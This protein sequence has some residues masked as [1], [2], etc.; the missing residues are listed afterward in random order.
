[1]ARFT[2]ICFFIT[3]ILGLVGHTSASPLDLLKRDCYNNPSDGCTK[4][5]N[6]FDA[7]P[8]GSCLGVLAVIGSPAVE[9]TG[10]TNAAVSFNIYDSSGNNIACVSEVPGGSSYTLCSSELEYTLEIN[11]ACGLQGS[12]T[13]S[14]CSMAYGSWSGDCI[15]SSG[16][17]KTDVGDTGITGGTAYGLTF[18]C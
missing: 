6:P 14:T 18:A 1:M 8:E 7:P 2:V 10:G 13:C 17:Q 3:A 5:G 12:S 15:S 4:N 11:D 16:A 9:P